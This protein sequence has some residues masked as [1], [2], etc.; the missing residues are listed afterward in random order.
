MFSGEK[1][2]QHLPSNQNVVGQSELL[3]DEE[4]ETFSSYEARYFPQEPVETK[5][6]LEGKW[7]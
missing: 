3:R 2:V 6:E 1:T 4:S 7:I 5:T